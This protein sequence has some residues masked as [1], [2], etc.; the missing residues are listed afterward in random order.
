MAAGLAL[1]LAFP[2]AQWSPLAFVGLAPLILAARGTGSRCAFLL[3]WMAG[4]AFFT[5]VVWW[6]TEAV[7]NYGYLPVPVGWAVMLMMTA[8]LAVFP[9][10]FAAAASLIARGGR[11]V[12]PAGVVALAAAWTVT[13][14]LRGMVP[15]GGFPW[16][17]LAYAQYLNLPFIQSASLAGPYLPSFVTAAIGAGAA[18]LWL[19]VAGREGRRR[20]AAGA[21]LAL[22][23]LGG[24]L[25]WGGW[26]LRAPEAGGGT[27]RVAVLQGNVPQEM[28]WNPEEKAATLDNYE[29]LSR[30]AAAGGAR[31]VVWPESAAPFFFQT[32]T[33]YRERLRRLA[34]DI[35]VPILFG[36]VGYETEGDRAR[37]R[38]RAYYLDAAGK[39]G[40]HY[41]K[42]HL[43]PFGE[44]VPMNKLLFFAGKLVEQVGDF[45]PGRDDRIFRAGDESFGTVICYEIIFPGLVRRFARDGA[46]FMTNITNDAWYGRTSASLQHFT[47]MVFRAVENGLPVARAANT[48]ISGFVDARGRIISMSGLFVRGAYLADLRPGREATFYARHGDFFPWACLLA[49]GAWAAAAVI[50]TLRGR[51]RSRS[52]K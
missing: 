18:C 43:V 38:N 34:K 15:F 10:L 20:E 1:A 17:Y 2:P 44:Y 39:V 51:S 46:T 36:T 9:G 3:G 22:A 48:G 30:E 47:Q 29:A 27:L 6:V 8:I 28:K 21:L 25:A 14:W 42:M 13:E 7:I 33:R 11:P 41:D 26:R 16:A 32:E 35:G 23:V 31:L 52:A 5:G 50:Q 19:A 49:L 4:F 24:N 37:L 40:G 45:T 12:G